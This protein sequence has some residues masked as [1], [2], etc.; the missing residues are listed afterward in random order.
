MIA[1]SRSAVIRRQ[2]LAAP[3]M[4]DEKRRASGLPVYRHIRY[5]K[6]R[7]IIAVSSAPDE[8]SK[9][10]MM[11]A[12]WCGSRSAPGNSLAW[13]GVYKGFRQRSTVSRHVNRR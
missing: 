12:G 6:E 8:K 3:K 5:F 10:E 13:F 11:Q 7:I 2:Q 1:R 4:N 9:F